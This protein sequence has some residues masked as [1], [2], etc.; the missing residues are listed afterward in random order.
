MVE[1]IRRK[2]NLSTLEYHSLD[3]MLDSI[4]IDKCNL[5]TYC[6]TGKAD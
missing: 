2:L 1:L 5:C 4:G 6:W 3:G